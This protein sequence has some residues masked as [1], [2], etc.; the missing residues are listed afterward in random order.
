MEPTYYTADVL[1]KLQHYDLGQ[2]ARNRYGN[3]LSRRYTKEEFRVE[4][5]NSDRTFMSAAANLAGLF[6]PVGDQIWKLGLN[7]QPIPVFP[8]ERAVLSSFETC[9]YIYNKS[10]NLVS[11]DPY[12]LQLDEEN[13]DLYS[14]L[15]LHTGSNITTFSQLVL[16]YD[17]L[18]IEDQFNYRLPKWTVSISRALEKFDKHSVYSLY[19]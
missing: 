14:Y 15:S 13:Q 5:T 2:Y 12:F 8:V 17:T 18:Y 1:G 16:I 7:W 9:P 19:F 6:P 10:Q 11:S 4:T 3:F